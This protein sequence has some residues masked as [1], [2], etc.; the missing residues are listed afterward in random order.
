[1]IKILRIVQLACVALLACVMAG[2][3][4]YSFFLVTEGEGLRAV[5]V[6]LVAALAFGLVCVDSVVMDKIR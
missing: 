2:A 4:I 3:G 5:Q 6:M 1:M